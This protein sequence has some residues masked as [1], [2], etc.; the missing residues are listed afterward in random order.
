MDWVFWAAHIVD[1]IAV[2]E[3]KQPSGLN[4]ISLVLLLLLLLRRAERKRSCGRRRKKIAFFS[5]LSISS[6]QHSNTQRDI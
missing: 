1:I 4:N 5:S 2:D 6:S 3:K